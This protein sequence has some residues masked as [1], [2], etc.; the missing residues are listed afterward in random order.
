MLEKPNPESE[1]NF[2][3][4]GKTFVTAVLPVWRIPQKKNDF[5]NSEHGHRRTLSPPFYHI[6][7]EKMRAINSYRNAGQSL[8]TEAAGRSLAVWSAQNG[9]RN[10]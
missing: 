7:C 1:E 5:V 6:P 4:K 8:K 10:Q 9:K 2:H 3:R